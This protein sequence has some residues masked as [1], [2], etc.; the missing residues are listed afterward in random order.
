[1]IWRKRLCKTP[2]YEYRHVVSKCQNKGENYR[3]SG[4]KLLVVHTTL[5]CLSKL[6]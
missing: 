1:M 2:G 4:F 3:I 6:S 5:P